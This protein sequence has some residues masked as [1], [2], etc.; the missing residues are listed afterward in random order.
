MRVL[1]TAFFATMIATGAQAQSVADFYKG[2]NIDLYVGYSVG[3]AYDLYARMLARHMSKHIPGN[4]TIIPKNMEGAGS[5]RLANW[6]FNVAPKDGTAFGI[7]GRG[8][9]FDPLLENKAAQF[10]ATRFNW[11]GS[12]NNEVSI[13][14]A[15]NTS[16][17][18]KFE[19]L[20]ERPLIVGG[21]STSADTDQFPRILNGVLGTKMKVVT[22]YPGGNEVGLA[23][24]RGEVQGRCGWSWSSVKTTHKKWFDEKKFIVL[25]QLGLNKHPDLSD[26]PLVVD[27]AK[28][29]E[30][31]Q[32]LKLVFARQVMGRPFIAP[33]GIPQ[34]RVDALRT[35][36]M[37]TTQD[38]EF[39][40]DAE[41][42]QMEI[43][44]VS[45]DKVQALVKETYSTPP[46][47][48]QKAASFLR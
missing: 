20:L 24:E 37:A 3:G 26:V 7:F 4:P 34:D 15:W 38:P 21:T 10:D 46:E 18:T 1:L 5:L 42:T 47:I 11:I 43:N 17:V 39:L 41:K 32:I 31:R 13:C 28:T 2:K 40:A 6:L 12:A 8:T 25:V 9:G 14:V 22:G 16:G 48:A 35:A 30:Q 29:D 27:L 23:M 36:F 33:P 45:G 19:D 44:P